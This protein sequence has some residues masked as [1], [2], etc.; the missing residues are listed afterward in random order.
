[1]RHLAASGEAT[2]VKR[3]KASSTMRSVRGAPEAH[4]LGEA[5]FIIHE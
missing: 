3:L 4:E 1:M 2:G 5:D